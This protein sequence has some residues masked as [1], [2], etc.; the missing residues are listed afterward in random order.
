METAL[1]EKIKRL[2]VLLVKKERIDKEVETLSAEVESGLAVRTVKGNGAPSDPATPTPAPSPVKERPVAPSGEPK[3][4]SAARAK[5]GTYMG[6]IKSLS[7]SDKKLVAAVKES[8]GIDE[9]INLAKR[10]RGKAAEK[11]GESPVD[12]SEGDPGPDFEGSEVTES[13]DEI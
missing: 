13:F 1:T 7:E 5:Q 6:V 3:P 10:I 11:R 12:D 8:Q 9:A 4:K 2:G